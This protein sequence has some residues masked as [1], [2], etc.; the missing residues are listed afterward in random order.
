VVP[1]TDNQGVCISLAYCPSSD[2]IVASYRPIFSMSMDVPLSQPLATPLSAGQGVQGTHV[3]FNRMG[4]HHFQKVGSSYANVSKIR[5]PKCVIM[6]IENQSRL[7]ASWDEVTCDL[8]LHELPSFRVLQ[9]FK[10]PA[11]AR[12]LRYSPSHG[13]LGC[14]SENTLQLFYSKHSSVR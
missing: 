5:L 7:F 6:D 13:I 11:Q 8:L 3:L 14:L 4:G 2:D 10:M 9:Q 12:D 1:E